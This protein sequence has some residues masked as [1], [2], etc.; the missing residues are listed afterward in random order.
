MP[1]YKE[2]IQQSSTGGEFRNQSTQTTTTR[3]CSYIIRHRPHRLPLQPS[4]S[5]HSTDMASHPSFLSTIPL[6][7]TLEMDNDDLS[8]FYTSIPQDRILNATRHAISRYLHHNPSPLPIEHIKFTVNHS[9]T[10]A[11]GR[12]FRGRFRRT[13]PSVRVIWLRHVLVLVELS[14]R[15]SMFDCCGTIFQQIRGSCIGSPLSPVLCNICAAFEEDV[16]ECAH[17]DMLL[18][19]K[20]FYHATRYV[21]NRLIPRFP[22]ITHNPAIA[23]FRS[24]DFYRPPV[25]LEPENSDLYLGFAINVDNKTVKYQIPTHSW[26]FRSHRSA[27]TP[28]RNL[29]GMM[30]RISLMYTW[31][32]Q[33]ADATVRELTEVYKGHGHIIRTR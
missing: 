18:S 16:W 27:G 32:P 10:A 9:K 31:P 22:H 7:Q 11:E 19:A 29:S 20:T 17:R 13:D 5:Q 28:A 12:V 30:S 8:G 26:E 14:L 3:P 23:T 25:Q 21:D 24:L 15:S 33:D 4:P 2:A 6:E 1:T